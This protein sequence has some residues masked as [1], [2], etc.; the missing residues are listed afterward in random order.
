VSGAEQSII[1]DRRARHVASRLMWALAVPLWLGA[2]SA[3][4][5]FGRLKPSLV[6]DD[7]HGWIGRDAAR[8]A[9]IP[10]SHYPLTDDER[11]LRDLAYPLIEPPYDR[12]RW[13]AVVNEYG[14]SHVYGWPAFDLTGYG[15]RLLTMQYRSATARYSQLNTDIRN[16]VL[17]IPD[18]FGIARRVLDLDH[19]RA[20]SLAY[21]TALTPHEELNAASRI[22]EN[23]LVVGWV[24][25]ALAE[26]SLAYCYT[27]QR[28]VI[29]TPTPMAVEVERSLTL[30]NTRIAEHR[31][32]TASQ[33]GSEP[34]VCGPQVAA[35]PLAPVAVVSK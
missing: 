16:D 21:V 11:L 32:L 23:E 12:H 5:D 19:K 33:F 20:Q 7:M 4:G 24:Q 25:R 15:T 17:R 10:A 18:F 27:L 28:L 14:A 34:V 31:P 26:R 9:G 2:C 13:H 29:A 22:A 35:A 3:N 6:S 1:S 30:L 8:A